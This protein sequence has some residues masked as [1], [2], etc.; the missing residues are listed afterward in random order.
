MINNAYNVKTIF[1]IKDLENL[2]GI[3]AHTIRIWEKR[4]NVLAPLR[5]E[6]N[7]RNYDLRSLQKLLNVVLLN[8]YGYKISRI[9]EHSEEKIE[10]LVRE[11]ISEKSTKNHAINAF[12]MA[13]INFDQALFLN[14]YNS[15][16][17]EKSFRD[18]F[19]EVVI[20]LMQEIGLLWQ[21]GTISPAQ[22]HFITFLIKQKLFLNIEKLQMREPTRTDKVFVLYLPENEIHELGLMYLNYEILFNGYKTIYLGESV[23]IDSLMDMN[24]YFDNIVYVSYLTVEPT[25]DAI[26]DYIEEITAKIINKNSQV[27]LLGRMVE[28]IDTKKISDKI[29]LHHSISAVVERL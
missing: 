4:Y 16:L 24:K 14:T 10:L 3:K 12:K 6:T 21:A 7:I 18:V 22:E 17:S 25:K 27:W 1:S 9:A 15:L 13:M 28:F 11:I 23:P 19:F 20:P 2:S 5:S 29:L 26:N 8:N